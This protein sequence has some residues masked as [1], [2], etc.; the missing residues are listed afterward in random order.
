MVGDRIVELC[1]HSGSVT[2][3]NVCAQTAACFMRMDQGMFYV[4]A[5]DGSVSSKG[6]AC[7]VRARC[8]RRRAYT[9]V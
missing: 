1:R 7:V 2:Q 6:V 5:A 4:T 3:A 8:C 9:V